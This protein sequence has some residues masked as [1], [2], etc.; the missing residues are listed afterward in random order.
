M[1]LLQ[2]HEPGQTPLPHAKRALAVGI[3][4]GTTN[5][6]V[7]VSENQQPLVLKDAAGLARPLMLIHGTADD[8][9]FF[10]HSLKLADALTRAG[11]RFEFLPLA[12]FT[13]MVPEPAM[14]EQRWQRTVEFFRRELG[15]EPGR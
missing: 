1:T 5:S 7:A 10:R 3:D 12:G 4:L 14:V 6:L 13:H 11:R 8:N 15:R 9:V 2:I